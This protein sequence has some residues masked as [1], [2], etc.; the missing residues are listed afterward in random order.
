MITLF[1][2]SETWEVRRF[3]DRL[4]RSGVADTLSKQKKSK[5]RPLHLNTRFCPLP[6]THT[7]TQ[8]ADYSNNYILINSICFSDGIR[9]R[10]IF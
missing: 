2:S 8:T 5:T 10:K 7:H 9:M 4:E 6:H 1:Y 3:A